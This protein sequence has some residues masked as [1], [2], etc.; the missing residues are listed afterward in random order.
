MNKLEHIKKVNPFLIISTSDIK[1]FIRFIL[2]LF[3]QSNAAKVK[4]NL[5]G[6][7][8]KTEKIHPEELKM[9][10]RGR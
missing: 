9:K 3:I 6:S 5:N 8:K 7:R 1:D 10:G 2:I 4:N